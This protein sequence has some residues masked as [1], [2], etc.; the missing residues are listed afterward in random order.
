MQFQER[1]SSFLSKGWNQFA[2]STHCM[3]V[4]F[5]TLLPGEFCQ[6]NNYLFKFI[7]QIISLY[8]FF[9]YFFSLLS[10]NF[11]LC[12]Q[13]YQSF[14]GSGFWIIFRQHSPTLRLNKNSS[15]LQ[16]L[17]FSLVYGVRYGC[18]FNFLQIATRLSQNHLS[19][20]TTSDLNYLFKNVF[21]Q[22][23]NFSLTVFFILSSLKMSF[24]CFPVSIVPGEKSS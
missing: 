10:L 8:L 18:N 11:F 16:Y 7:L 9:Y 12:H 15:F 2:F 17:K 21:F 19:I 23:Q 6:S 20:F 3:S 5:S 22:K 13:T 1:L 14:T 4:C 24:H